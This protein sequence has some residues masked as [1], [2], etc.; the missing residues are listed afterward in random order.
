MT[1][2]HYLIIAKLEAYGVGKNNFKTHAKLS[3]PK[4]TKGKSWLVQGNG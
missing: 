3:F 1:A 4:T 2:N